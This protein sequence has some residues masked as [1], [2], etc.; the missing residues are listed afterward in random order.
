M[1]GD[2]SGQSMLYTLYYYI[3]KC[4]GLR[5]ADK[6]RDLSPTSFEFGEDENGQF[7]QFIGGK[8]KNFRGGLAEQKVQAKHYHTVGSPRSLSVKVH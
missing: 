3:S 2:D 1:F 4:F 5:A 8:C 6:H 7:V